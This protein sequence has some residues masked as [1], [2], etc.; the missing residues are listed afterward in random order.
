MVRE[1]CMWK[2][3]AAGIVVMC[4]VMVAN[5]AVHLLNRPSDGAVAIG[6]LILLALVA[7]GVGLFQLYRRR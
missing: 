6:Y 4:S 5:F 3:L 1:V 7:A 2:V